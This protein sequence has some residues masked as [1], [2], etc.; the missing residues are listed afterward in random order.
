MLPLGGGKV[1]TFLRALIN[2]SMRTNGEFDKASLPIVHW[3]DRHVTWYTKTVQNLFLI[4]KEVFTSVCFSDSVT[5]G[6]TESVTLRK[7]TC[8]LLDRED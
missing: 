3:R 7:S 2:C 1:S 6:Q 4:L 8:P 5:C